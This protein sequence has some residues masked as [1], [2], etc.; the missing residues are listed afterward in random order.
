MS[1]EELQAKQLY[2]REEIID[3][4]YDPSDFN[5]FMCNIRQE[6]SIDLNN[7]TLDELKSVVSNY[8][9]SQMAKEKEEEENNNDNQQDNNNIDI[10]NDENN[11]NEELTDNTDSKSSSNN[12][13]GNTPFE[14]YQQESICAKLEKNELTERED[15]RI[16]I[17][18][19]VKVNPGF[20]SISYFQYKLTTYPLNICVIRKLSDFL[21]LNEKLQLI[22][23]VIYTPI[24]PVFHYGV[25]DD[26]PKKLRYIQ[27]Y[28]NLLLENKFFRSLQIVHDFIFLSLEDWNQKMKKVYSKIKMAQGFSKMP[29]M[30]GKYTI[31]ISKEDDNK[32]S[33]IKNE[34]NEKNEGLKNLNYYLD[35]LISLLD[36]VSQSLKNIGVCFFSMEKTEQNL[37]QNKTLIKGY[38]NLGN[39]FKVWGDDYLKQR[40][41]IK[42]EIKYYFKFMSKEYK[43]FMKKYDDYKA[44]REEYKKTWEKTKKNKTKEDFDS[45][46][47]IKKYYGYELS[48]VN[49][50]YKKLEERMEKRLMKQFVCFN[51]GK[52]IF[53]Q[54][55]N[56][57]I[58][59]L[60]FNEKEKNEENNEIIN[61]KEDKEENENIQVNNN[62]EDNNI[63]KED[64]IQNENNDSIN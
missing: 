54:D 42:E 60:N 32:A 24:F 39:L 12:T 7:W 43:T 44:G 22:H 8:K 51:Q 21:F 63:I 53:F 31:K 1:E 4:G 38:N 14:F 29:N 58:K 46:K 52:D 15:L 6:E 41:F 5:I 27:N 35:E 56:N 36:K 26:S 25:K 64:N 45:L 28:M 37:Q 19:P 48:C 30:E 17:S 55:M 9:E 50:E 16:I 40:D 18:D 59:L 47:S 49:D 34:L 13:L 11:I 33:L 3:K 23:P 20:F 61:D 2:L 62:D 57:C 10:I